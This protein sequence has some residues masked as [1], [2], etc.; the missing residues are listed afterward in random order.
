RIFQRYLLFGLM[1]PGTDRRLLLRPLKRFYWLLLKVQSVPPI[2]CYNL[3]NLLLVF[4]VQ[5]LY[6]QA[7]L[8]IPLI[9][10]GVPGL[11]LL[12]CPEPPQ[13]NR[14]ASLVLQSLMR[15]P[16]LPFPQKLSLDVLLRQPPEPI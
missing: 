13:E 11:V 15:S 7:L 12:F 16:V 5:A 9:H 4:L 2:P 3:R 10:L 6:P 14:T 8:P 1:L